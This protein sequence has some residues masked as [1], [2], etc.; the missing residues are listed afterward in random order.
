MIKGAP[1]LN[2]SS[3]SHT[4][5]S[6]YQSVLSPV[7]STLASSD[8]PIRHID[9]KY[10]FQ[11]DTAGTQ[12]DLLKQENDILKQKVAKLTE[13]VTA[14]EKKKEE[15]KRASEE[16]LRERESDLE[17]AKKEL[18]ERQS[19]WDSE[20]QQYE[21]ELT[22]MYSSKG[23]SAKDRE[24]LDLRRK[25]NEMRSNERMLR[26]HLKQANDSL[27]LERKK[28]NLVH[29][30]FTTRNDSPWKQPLSRSGRLR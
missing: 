10:T 27:E 6:V 18:E 14:V 2:Q 26:A 7:A 3:P 24:I 15:E 17:D 19:E 5:N 23:E 25:L 13:K 20:K 16:R 28:S 29:R 12:V 9:S 22:R 21:A 11:A 4:G 8:D 30:K 1:Q